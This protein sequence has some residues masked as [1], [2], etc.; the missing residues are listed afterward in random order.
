VTDWATAQWVVKLIK[1]VL[2]SNAKGIK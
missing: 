1:S 2:G